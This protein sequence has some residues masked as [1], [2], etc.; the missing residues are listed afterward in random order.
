MYNKTEDPEDMQQ[1]AENIKE[2]VQ[3]YI[4]LQKQT[5]RLTLIQYLAKMG[6]VMMDGVVGFVLICMVLQFGAITAGFWLSQLTGSYVKGFGLLTLILL[7]VAIILHLCRKILFVN[8][9]LHRLVKKLHAGP[10]SQNNNDH[11]ESSPH[12]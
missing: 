9:V 6:G 5:V 12:H 8:P 11:E 4:F 2:L 10:A 1:F 3:E 7:A